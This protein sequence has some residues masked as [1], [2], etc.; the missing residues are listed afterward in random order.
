MSTHQ[1]DKKSQAW[2]ALFSEPMSELVKR[3]TS[4]VT[5]D[6][7]LWRADIAGSTMAGSSRGPNSAMADIRVISCACKKFHTPVMCWPFGR[8]DRARFPHRHSPQAFLA[9]PEQPTRKRRILAAAWP[10]PALPEP[11]RKLARALPSRDSQ[12]ST[13]SQH[14]VWRTD[15]SNRHARGQ[16]AHLRRRLRRL[17]PPPPPPLLR[18][19]RPQRACHPSL[20]GARRAH[21]GRSAVR[22]ARKHAARA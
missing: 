17:S 16:R 21:S 6:K 20:A 7:R 13:G 12:A 9:R 14:G 10:L 18:H 3:Y 19:R 15:D 2:S 5:F 1:L 4:S 11:R 8:T 22:K